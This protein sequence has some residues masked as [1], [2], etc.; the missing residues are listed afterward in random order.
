MSAHATEFNPTTDYSNLIT[1]ANLDLQ[2]RQEK[3]VEKIL[4]D[5]NIP[6]DTVE[7]PY[8]VGQECNYILNLNTTNKDLA[9]TT[10]SSEAEA[11]QSLCGQ[12]RQ[13]LEGITEQLLNATP[14]DE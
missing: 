2:G 8:V 5:P 10:D 11:K 14:L 3:L 4:N 6:E 13:T 7:N 12:I 1:D 9:V